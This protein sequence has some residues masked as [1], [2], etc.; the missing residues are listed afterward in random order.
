M[1]FGGPGDLRR[2]PLKLHELAL[3]GVIVCMDIFVSFV[4][5]F[6]LVF[7]ISLVSATIKNQLPLSEPLIALIVGALIGLLP[8]VPSKLKLGSASHSFI[9]ALAEI[10]LTIAL[11]TTA[12]QVPRGY[13]RRRWKAALLLLGVGM[14]L[15]WAMSSAIVY[16]TL[17]LP[18]WIAMLIGAGI[19]PTDPVLASTI[20]S[21][22]LAESNIAGRIR[23]LVIVESGINDGLAYVFVLLPLNI[24]TH[25]LPQAL[26]GWLFY[27]VLWET[28]GA[29]LF[30]AL[31]GLA[32][33]W[34][35]NGSFA[36]E[37]TEH[38]S[39]LGLT[40]ALALLTLGALK[41]LGTD[42]ILG[43][44]AA[45]LV[46]SETL[47]YRGH[48]LERAEH[49]QE[50]VER[51][52]DLPIFVVLGA[53][54]P[55][56]AWLHMGW[57]AIL[58]AVLVLALRRLPIVT[59]LTPLLRPSIR[60]AREGLFI[61]WFGPIGISALFYATLAFPASSQLAAIWPITTLVI[62]AS[63][64]AHGV[65]ATQLTILFG[66]LVTY[67]ESSVP[68]EQEAQEEG[69]EAVA[70]DI[71]R[72][73]HVD[74]RQTVESQIEGIVARRLMQFQNETLGE[75]TLKQHRNARQALA[76]HARSPEI[77]GPSEAIE[78]IAHEIAQE[79]AQDI[80]DNAAQHVTEQVSSNLGS[81]EQEQEQEQ[82]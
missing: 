70:Q 79:V 61:G 9:H 21:G 33:G 1:A 32:A 8:L 23:H 60:T 73:V 82:S 27:S 24:L 13:L 3:S 16:V 68:E 50:A 65:S 5:V 63:I 51:F 28:G 35:A 38:T 7:L 48:E 40:L 54:L 71:A 53:V 43:V 18:L 31:I 41:L 34:L 81:E 55:W 17:G 44:F 78:V 15:M 59:L 57:S 29:L 62:V 6:G 58:V 66:R 49:V 76:E 14:P 30:G 12:L 19:T 39:F 45:G 20:V 56:Q 4:V 75:S 52:F 11:M 26:S 72:Q 2:F 80:S 69:A 67:A 74:V 22:H 64:V 36:V 37:A 42:A 47:G 46:F 25:P 77:S 10:T